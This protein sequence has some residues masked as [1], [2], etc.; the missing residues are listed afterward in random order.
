MLE[1]LLLQSLYC[2]G[3]YHFNKEQFIMSASSCGIA[4]I[5]VSP[6]C[7]LMPSIPLHIYVGIMIISCADVSFI[8]IEEHDDVFMKWPNLYELAEILDAN[9]GPAFM[10]YSLNFSEQKLEQS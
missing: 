2:L 6:I 8:P 7:G 3:Q 5:V 4:S 1:V 9:V 10:K